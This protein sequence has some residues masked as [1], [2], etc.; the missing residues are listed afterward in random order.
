MTLADKRSDTYTD[1]YS[2]IRLP[3][4]LFTLDISFNSSP[5]LLLIVIV[6]RRHNV[7]SLRVSCFDI[8]QEARFKVCHNS[9]DKSRRKLNN[10]TCKSRWKKGRETADKEI[11]IYQVHLESC[12]QPGVSGSTTACAKNR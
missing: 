4:N 10:H 5:V 12:I 7:A 2:D 11:F 3:Q 9:C 6:K 8:V 1:S